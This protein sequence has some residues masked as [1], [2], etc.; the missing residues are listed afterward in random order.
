[1]ILASNGKKEDMQVNSS[2]AQRSW[3]IR[4]VSEPARGPVT[5]ETVRELKRVKPLR[6]VAKIAKKYAKE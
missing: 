1:M 4:T 5:K 2:A 3:T 6:E